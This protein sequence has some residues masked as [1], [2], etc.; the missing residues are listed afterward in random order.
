MNVAAPWRRRILSVVV[1]L[2]LVI[3]GLVVGMVVERFRFDAAR[4]EVLADYTRATSQLHE[5]LMVLEPRPASRPVG[6]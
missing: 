4:A 5:R 6:R 1:G 3:L 2:Y